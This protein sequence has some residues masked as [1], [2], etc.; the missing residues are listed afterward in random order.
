MWQVVIVF[1]GVAAEGFGVER[2]DAYGKSGILNDANGFADASIDLGGIRAPDRCLHF[3][4]LAV[5]LR[6]L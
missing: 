5:A 6:V 2:L 4:F 1:P 3:L